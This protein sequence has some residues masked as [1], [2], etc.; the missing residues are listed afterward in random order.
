MLGGVGLIQVRN[1]T[2]SNLEVAVEVVRREVI[3]FWTYS[4]GKTNRNS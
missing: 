1:N 2:G 4:E 3:G